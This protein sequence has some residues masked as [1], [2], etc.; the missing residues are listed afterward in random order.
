LRDQGHPLAALDA[1]DPWD[2]F[3]GRSIQWSRTDGWWNDR[4]EK[5]T[6]ASDER[7]ISRA[8]VLNS[9]LANLAVLAHRPGEFAIDRKFSLLD[10]ALGCC[11]RALFKT[12]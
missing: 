1:N 5:I 7:E 6:T 12:C 3:L 10:G 9:S 4:Q 11:P 2:R 8:L